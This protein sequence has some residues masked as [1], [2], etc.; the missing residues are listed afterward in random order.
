MRVLLDFS[1]LR[2]GGGL[3]VASATLADLAR[4][5]VQLRFAEIL[6][7]AELWI[8]PAVARNLTVDRRALPGK[9]VVRETKPSLIAPLK[10]PRR[11]F[12]VR[13]TLFGP[14][15]SGRVARRE[16]TGFA[17]VT[18]V[19]LPGE[20]GQTISQQPLRQRLG[21]WVKRQLV[22]RFDW[23]VVEAPAIA[24]RLTG[25]YGIAGDR[26]FVVPNRPHPIFCDSPIL[27]RSD[28]PADPRQLHV[29]F[30]TRAYP[31]KNMELIGPAGDRFHALAG[32]DL[33]VHVTLRPDE[34]AAL[35][36][37]VRRWMVN[38]GESTLPDVLRI[39][40]Q[41]QGVFFSSKLEA[42]SGTPLEAN[43]LGL[44]LLASD[45]DFIRGSARAAFLFDPEDADSAAQALARLD[46][47]GAQAW[48]EA[49][50]RAREYRDELARTSR[51][52]Q[53]LT[54]VQRALREL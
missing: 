35:S 44:P 33:R 24:E 25:R 16:I 27:E 8:S 41:V 43:V 23:Y 19:Y 37:S 21:N 50:I 10:P 14:T 1:N 54:L 45:R 32:K 22:R 48:D 47:A 13:F 40:R 20:Y 49:S 4:P 7:G 5:E 18:L 15:Y 3:Q 39:Y 52:E 12:D 46:R 30:P 51:T 6:E 28:A 53:Y 2:A 36:P 17:E 26:I 11:A 34:W 42:S 31:H 29:A 9:V 38:H